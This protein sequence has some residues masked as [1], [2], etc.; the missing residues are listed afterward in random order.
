MQRKRFGKMACLIA[1]SLERV[2]EWWSILII[3]DALHGFTRF[4]GFQKS[5]NI[6]PNADA[7]LERLGRGR[8]FT[9]PPLQ[10]TIAALRI[11]SNRDGP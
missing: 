2:G 10:R 6:A 3:R 7:P 8:S 4:D 5:L 9:A 1:R 11:Y